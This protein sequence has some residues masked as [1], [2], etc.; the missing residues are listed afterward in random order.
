MLSAL[1]YSVAA[2]LIILGTD[3]VYH[4]VHRSLWFD[5]G[6]TFDASGNPIDRP[7]R[8]IQFGKVIVEWHGLFMLMAGALLGAS[9]YGLRRRR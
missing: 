5:F 8:T 1:G 9:T 6:M 2:V 3:Q 7:R 4:D